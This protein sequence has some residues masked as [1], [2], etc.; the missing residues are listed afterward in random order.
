MKAK[1][2]LLLKG[3]IIFCFAC[4]KDNPPEQKDLLD[5]EYHFSLKT[6]QI[7]SS[8]DVGNHYYIFYL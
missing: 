2:I 1:K 7:A 5:I 4:E 8:D 6:G 3:V